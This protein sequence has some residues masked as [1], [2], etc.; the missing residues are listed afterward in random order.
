MPGEAMSQSRLYV[1]RRWSIVLLAA[2]AVGLTVFACITGSARAAFGIAA[3]DQQIAGPAEEPFTQ[4]GGHPFEIS[5]ELQ[6]NDHVNP[7]Y[8]GPQPDEETRDVYSELPPGLVG[9]P[10]GLPQCTETQLL[11]ATH[12]TKSVA[13]ECP[14]DSQVGTI[15]LK[16]PWEPLLDTFHFQ[17]FNMVPPSGR[18]AAFGF[19]VAGVPI[20]L[21][22]NVRNG[23]DFGITVVS[24][25]IPV[26]FPIA[27]F[28]LTFWGVPG[29]PSHD[30]QRCSEG[31]LEKNFENPAEPASC[32]QAPGTP[33]GPHSFSG[34]PK[35][36]LTLP[37]SCTAPGVGF[38]T[39]FRVDSWLHPG[40]FAEK[41]LFNHLGPGYPLAAAEWGPQQALTGCDRVPFN[42]RVSVQPTNHQAD[43]PTGLNIDFS[44]PQD[45]LLDPAGTATADVEKTVVTLPAG[46]AV[47]PS[48]AGGL[49]ACSPAEIA[50]GSGHAAACPDAS[51]LGSVEIDTPLLEDPLEGS[52][53]LARQS[54]NP[55]GSL[56]AL[57]L[58]AEGHGVVLK[59]AGRV[60]LNPV[61][62]RLT[63]TFDNSP[64]LPF[65]ELKVS[66]KPGPR[67]PIVNPPAC[68]SYTANAQLTPWSGNPP[69]EVS[70]TFQVTSGPDGG[71]CPGAPQAFAPGFSAGTTSNQAGG[72]SPFSLTFTRSDGEQQLGRVS[73]KMPLG[74]LG[75]LAGIPLCPEPQASQG[76]CDAASQ[77]GAVTVG[78]GAG[79][80]PFYVHGGRVY[81]T[82][83]YNGAPFGLSIVVPAVAG[84]FDLG[85]VVVRATIS[86]DP[87]T[88]QL[89][90]SSDP[91]PTVLQGIPLDL[92]VVN[93]SVDRPGF[94]F[95]ATS[96]DRMSL[97]GTLTGGAG[98]SEAVSSGYQV[99]NCGS[100]AFKP[101][102]TVS[103]NGK[104]SRAGGA[105]LDAKIVYPTGAEANIA[106]VKVD[107]PKQLPSRLTT[108][109]KA[110]TAAVFDANPA[111]CPAA[112]L[113][114]SATASTPVLPV[115]LSGP[116]Y[117]VS[118]GG[119]AFPSLIVV[120]QGYGVTVDL[121][122]DTFISKAG[123]TSSTFD[124]VPDVPIS[125]FELKLPQ[126][127]NSALAANGN[128]CTAKLVMPTLFVAHDGAQIKQSTRIVATGCA[129]AGKKHPR[130][131]AKHARHANSGAGKE[132]V[133]KAR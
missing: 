120:L 81:L 100:L 129:K 107:L 133:L 71:A 35:A 109:Q 102:F 127:R 2:V 76:T 42:P 16:T 23:G 114:G 130:R 31:F 108:L 101:K 105:S 111:N 132:R 64:Q 41:T 80:N 7:T 70:D 123:I 40:V 57:Y 113:V 89:S 73:L 27:G 126:G 96:C 29:D 79:A 90:I 87:H 24:A 55:F 124:T 72:F 83:G 62:G 30:A 65:T 117:F 9:N 58:V 104:T 21:T 131:R 1:G 61:S 67:S 98:G 86:V 39:R 48:A 53:Y 75:T 38:Q 46:M 68:G 121:V 11:A 6:V 97:D 33:S 106:K 59:L 4:A 13:G 88:A 50:L 99:T 95:N 82:G 91:L 93:V 63:A 12:A 8:G 60:D 85:T 14:I 34:S 45:G 112:S 116:V 74:L 84:P 51:K 52:V 122:G 66:L 17:V 47:S 32:R 103:T 77:I 15:D 37:V 44:L 26:A 3:A 110:C 5:T 128:L 43:T 18:P 69:I 92:R 118:H 19:N 22:G 25:N 28:K 119:E 54:D 78:A 20:I 36:F 56:V 115:Q 10:V 94:I 49:D 125:R